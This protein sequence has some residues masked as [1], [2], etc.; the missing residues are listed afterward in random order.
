MTA[1]D[2]DTFYKHAAFATVMRHL[3]HAMRSNSSAALYRVT[4]HIPELVQLPT[5]K[6]GLE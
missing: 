2:D 5:G 1:V 3:L 6:M 4:R